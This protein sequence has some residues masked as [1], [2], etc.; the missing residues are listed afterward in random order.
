MFAITAGYHRYFSH[1][2]YKTSRAFQFVLAWVGCSSAQKGPLWWA[3]HHRTHHQE[4]DGP[5]DIHSPVRDGFWWSHVGWILS[6]KYDDTDFRKIPDLARYPEL[7]WLN[8]HF[9]IPPVVWALACLIMGGVT[10]QVWV[11]PRHHRLGSNDV[12]LPFHYL[13]LWIRKS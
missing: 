3:A 12:L 13:P 2:T 10:G 7:V 9:L 4:S 8:K 6:E 1:R 5:A 11:Q